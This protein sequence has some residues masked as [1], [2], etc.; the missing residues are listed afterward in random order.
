MFKW[1]MQKRETEGVSLKRKCALIFGKYNRWKY[2]SKI[3]L[4]RNGW[5]IMFVIRGLLLIRLDVCV[6]GKVVILRL[7]IWKVLSIL[8]QNCVSDIIYQNSNIRILSISNLIFLKLELTR[9]IIPDRL[10]TRNKLHDLI[11]CY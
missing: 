2:E 10:K 5:Q 7:N 3:I 1:Y 6:Q 11:C 8:E 9:L 4:N